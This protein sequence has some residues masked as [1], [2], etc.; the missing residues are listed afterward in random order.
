[1]NRDFDFDAYIKE[2]FVLIEKEREKLKEEREVFEQD[3]IKFENKKTAYYV[4]YKKENNYYDMIKEELKEISNQK[5]RIKSQYIE[6]EE[7]KKALEKDRKI[8]K[9]EYETMY[10]ERDNFERQRMMI[11]KKHKDLQR[12]H[13]ENEAQIVTMQNEYRELV[14]IKKELRDKS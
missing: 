8:I 1:M 6:I 10:E 5:I 4:K 7:T 3:I 12:I 2:Q 13:D 11:E 9:K 14:K